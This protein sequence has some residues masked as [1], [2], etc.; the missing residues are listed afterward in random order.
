MVQIQLLFVNVSICIQYRPIKLEDN[1]DPEIQQINLGNAV[2]M[3]K[4]L[5]NNDLIDFHFLDPPHM[6]GH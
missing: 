2:S 1:T 3:L 5:G 4:T 6:R